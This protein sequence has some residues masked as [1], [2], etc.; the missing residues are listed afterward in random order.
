MTENDI[1]IL[2]EVRTMTGGKARVYYYQGNIYQPL[3]LDGCEVGRVKGAIRKFMKENSAMVDSDR[4]SPDYKTLV[5]LF[6]EQNREFG[7]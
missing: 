3:F 1:T 7:T 4:A 5:E 6:D 2:Q